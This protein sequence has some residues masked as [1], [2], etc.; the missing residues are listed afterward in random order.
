M[1][2]SVLDMVPSDTPVLGVVLTGVGQTEA[3][4]AL[5]QALDAH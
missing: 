1:D 2:K 5:S 3:A 4:R